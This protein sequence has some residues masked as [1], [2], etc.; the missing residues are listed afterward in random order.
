MEIHVISGHAKLAGVMG[1]PIS[2]S[3]SPRLHGFWLNRYGIDGAYVPIPVPPDH[4]GEVIKALPHMG[5]Q[6]FNITM[7][8]KKEAMKYMDSIHPLAQRVGAINTVIIK[9]DGKMEGRNTDVFGF[10]E[11]LR[12]ANFEGKGKVATV[13]GSGG[14]ARAIIVGLMDMGCGE[15][16]IVN[17]SKG[18]AE[19]I[20]H[21]LKSDEHEGGLKVF[22][23]GDMTRALYGSSLLVNTTALGMTGQAPL[24]VDLTPLP[25]DAVVTDIVNS[26]LM[27]DFLKRAKE[28]GLQ[29]I[30]GLGMLLHQARPGFAAWFGKDPEVTEELRRFVLAK[31]L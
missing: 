27:T 11:S 18:K 24:D 20:S 13:L 25:Y 3:K 4:L 23:W 1:W 10:T 22:E 16:R 29:I 15:I 30:D 17:R 7:P 28:R 21:Q 19:E 8:H 14:A 2:Q 5:F 9:P 31:T 26:P 6:G 12:F